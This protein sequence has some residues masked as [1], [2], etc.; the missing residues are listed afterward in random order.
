VKQPLVT[1]A[2]L[3]G[4]GVVLG[5]LVEAPLV[6]SFAAAFA[7]ALCGLCWAAARLWLACAAVFLFGWINMSTRTAV[8][9]PIDL[10]ALLPDHATLVAV[11]GHLAE[12]PAERLMSRDGV[13]K[14]HTIAVIEVDSIRTAR[15][16]WQPAFGC[17][18]SK[19]SGTLPAPF[20]RGQPVEVTGAA[21]QPQPPM[22][23]GLFDY[24]RYLNSRGI[25]F[26]LKVDSPAE[27]Q[28]AGRAVG[29]PLA[30][31]FR[32][33][34]RRTLARG[35]PEMDESLRLQWAMLLGW[36]TA[37][38]SEVSEPFMRSGTMHIF[39]ISGLHIA[40]IA[41]IFLAL[42]RAAMVPRVPCGAA[43]IAIL[44]FYTAATGW[45]PS[46]IRSSVMMTVVIAGQMFK[47]PGNLLNSL[48][49]A[50]CV[51]L[52]W[53]PEQL[54]Q[55]SFQLSFFVVLSLALLEPPIDAL[56][57]RLFTLD[58]FLP[59]E[60]RPWW[61][62]RAIKIGRGVWKGFA[63]SLAA[64]LGSMP[65]IAFYFNLF[66]P[67]SLLANLVIVP[68]SSFA[69]MSGLGALVT[70]D[71]L[72]WFTEWF[73]HSG[74]FF[75]RQMVWLS[76]QAANVP[77]AWWH[78]RG[79]SPVL[80]VLY[81]GLLVAGSAGWLAQRR[82]R[83][84]VLAAAVALAAFWLVQRQQERSW[85]RV[86]VL[87]LNGGHAVCVEP[88]H[89]GD[90][91][92][93]NCGDR[94]AVEFTV[95]SFW[96]AQGGNRIE[97]LLLTHGDARFVGGAARLDELFPIRHAFASPVASRSSS[98]REVL[99]DLEV[100]SNLHRSATNGFAAGPWKIV[101]PNSSDRFPNAPDNAVVALGEFD[102]V[103][104]L[105][106]AN[107]GRAGQKAVFDRHP[108]LR[109]DIVI[110]GLK[111]EPL[112][113]EWL[114]ALRPKLIVVADSDSASNRAEPGALQELRRTGA[115]VIQTRAAGAVTFSLRQ[116]T[117]QVRTARP[118]THFEPELEMGVRGAPG[119]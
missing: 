75:M 72:P 99:S 54:F 12:T 22:A 40:L 77:G 118:V 35:L 71:V 93:I 64:F 59:W 9:S 82:L 68:I 62:R 104:V 45:Q 97:N 36:Q 23:P 96:Q 31:R 14:S 29:T 110:A 83:W 5:N 101:H 80:F 73:N 26:E 115:E 63:T 43:V 81:Y 69:L 112:A 55:A 20:V 107:L 95:K 17:V 90:E 111:G 98:Y 34:G 88:A 42:F 61:Q 13:E 113:I 39:A 7:F 117:W 66:T 84:G 92:W 16:G 74:W 94:G 32:A 48:A 47:R 1:V 57:Q 114:A 86:T 41:G 58:P 91:W 24:A 109:A 67:G 44:W 65:L 38:T 116:G 87:P 25:Y 11:R 102:G 85:H 105:C 51:I 3:Y 56:K 30:D 15:G 4:A 27:W 6:L 76:E 10:R 19:T 33:W 28:L 103:R 49:A 70:G 37:L 119:E 18:M 53:E 100:K 60:L 106:L 21:L 52:V 50:A 79:P 89:G 78:V 108:S 8:L 2:L 46:A